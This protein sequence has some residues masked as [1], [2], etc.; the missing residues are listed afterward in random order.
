MQHKFLVKEL[1]GL[2]GSGKRSLEDAETR[3]SALCSPFPRTPGTAAG[4]LG[5]AL[6][7]TAVI[8]WRHANGDGWVSAVE[9]G[10]SEPSKINRKISEQSHPP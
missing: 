8:S 5:L 1:L 2:N 4:P 6:L 10:D 9:E 7:I 3:S